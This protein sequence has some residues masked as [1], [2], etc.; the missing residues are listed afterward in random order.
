MVG[1]GSK[2]C[3]MAIIGMSS[4]E[5]SDSSTRALAKETNVESFMEGSFKVL[6]TGPMSLL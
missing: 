6:C 1:T 4:F 5:P 3:L 2:S